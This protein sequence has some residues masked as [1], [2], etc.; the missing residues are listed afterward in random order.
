MLGAVIPGKRKAL[1]GATN[2]EM[3][4]I[5]HRFLPLVLCGMSRP[6]SPACGGELSFRHGR[7][8]PGHVRPATNGLLGSL[9]GDY[10]GGLEAWG[11][12]EGGEKETILGLQMDFFTSGNQ[13]RCWGLG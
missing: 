13:K 6:N 5:L 4:E 12:A 10:P 11:K 7:R 1:D 2:Q 9:P 8:D 3:V